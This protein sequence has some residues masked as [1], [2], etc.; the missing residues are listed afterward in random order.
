MN[1][2]EIASTILACLTVL[3]IVLRGLRRLFRYG[4]EVLEHLRTLSTMPA[5][6]AAIRGAVVGLESRVETLERRRLW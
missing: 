2:L 3:G 5:D 4:R 6:V 1:L